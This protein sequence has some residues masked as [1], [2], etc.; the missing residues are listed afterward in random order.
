MSPAHLKAVHRVHHGPL[1][2]Q[3]AGQIGCVRVDDDKDQKRIRD[4][5]QAPKSRQ[6]VVGHQSCI[7][8]AHGEPQAFHEIRS[9]AI[10][11]EEIVII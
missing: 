11:R 2:D 5:E 7:V 9:T 10:L 3:V 4:T 8:R 1:S 6:R